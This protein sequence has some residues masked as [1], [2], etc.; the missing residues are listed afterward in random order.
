[1]KTRILNDKKLP[2]AAL[3]FAQFEQAEIIKYTPEKRG[4]FE[5]K[6]ERGDFFVKLFPKKFQ[7][8]KRGENIHLVGQKFWNLAHKGKLDFCV[9]KPFL[10]DAKTLTLW[11]KKLDGIH[12]VEFLKN[13]RHENL[14]FQIGRAIAAI[15]DLKIVPMRRCNWTE[16]IGDSR[17]FAERLTEKFP[18]L[19]NDTEK[20]L[21]LFEENQPAQTLVP[22]HGDMHIDQWLFDGANLG[23]LDFEDF[24]LA[25]AERDLAFFIVQIETEYGAEI[26]AARVEKDLLAGFVSAG[27]KVNEMLLQIYKAHKFLAKAAKAQSEKTTAEMMVKAFENLR[28]R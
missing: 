2:T 9:P 10:W 8:D 23:L 1:M 27:K 17:D 25:D 3:F 22:T 13:E 14:A 4:L 18:Y 12:A 16:Q 15:A 26:C 19:K 11:Q 7:R 5:V 28:M 24:S 6:T 20:L 21:T